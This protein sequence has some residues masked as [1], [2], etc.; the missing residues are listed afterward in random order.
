MEGADS[1]TTHLVVYCEQP[2]QVE[3]YQSLLGLTGLKT[4]VTATEADFWEALTSHPAD[5]LLLCTT[6]PEPPAFALCMKLKDSGC[7]FRDLPIVIVFPEETPPEVTL[8]AL[9]I[10]AYDYLVEP[11]NEIALLTKITVLARIKRAEDE[12]RQ[13]AI[14]DVVTGLYDRRYLQIRA[15]EELSRAKRYGCPIAFI[16]LS[17]DNLGQAELEHGPGAGTVVLQAIAEELRNLKR[18][19]DV[20]AKQ[21]ANQF[22]MVLYNTDEPGALVVANRTLIKLCSCSCGLGGFEPIASIGVVAVSTALD[23]QVQA[24]ALFQ[25]AETARQRAQHKGGNCIVLYTAELTP[26]PQSI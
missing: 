7:T 4:L 3:R 10:G 26:E 15:D 25:Q 24:Q 6:Y 5:L 8:Q 1:P 21:T 20:L 12:F 13:L 18:Q 11:F 17:I 19:I 14:T 9:H 16:T 23:A 22:T 2:C